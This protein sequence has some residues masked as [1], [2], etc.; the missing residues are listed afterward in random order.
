[1]S[2]YEY[3]GNLHI[4]TPYSDGEALHAEVAQAAA[5]AGLDFVI[6]TDHNVWV[7]GCERYYGKVLL[8]VGEE[9]HD[10]RRRPQ[11]NHLLAYNAEAE[12]APLA[13]DPQGL[14]DAVNQRGGL[15]YLAHPV[16]YGS[17]INRSLAP[18]PWTDWDVTGYAGL[19]IWN[20]MSEFKSLL[21]NRLAAIYYAYFPAQGI[22]GPFRATLRQWDHLLS[23]GRRVA[24][25]GGAD[26]HGTSYSI[27]PLRRVVQPYTYLFRCVNTHILTE[28]PFNGRLEHDKPLIYGALRA[29]HTWVG[30]DLLAPTAGF[31][32]QAHSIGNRAMMGDELA[33]IGAT[34]FEVETP[35]SGDIRLVLNGRVVARGGGRHLKHTT[36]EPGAYRVEVYRNYRLGRRGWIFSSPIYVS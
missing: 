14:I 20:Y 6:A 15:C 35:Y 21:R 3:A 11:A 32:F 9:V 29:G 18:I 17:P 26:A 23:Q 13:S 31:R 2:N 4:H 28:K 16:E 12:L 22:R 33:R 36:A 8:L 24:A 30:Y 5:E 7:N 25:I 19:E 27:G 1:M 34:V 10:V